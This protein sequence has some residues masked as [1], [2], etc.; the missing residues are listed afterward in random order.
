GGF[1]QSSS[2]PIVAPVYWAACAT[3]ND[4]RLPYSGA[5]AAAR[6]IV[7]HRLDQRQIFAVNPRGFTFHLFAVLP[8]FPRNFF[9][10]FDAGRSYYR[11]FRK[12][13]S[14]DVSWLGSQIPDVYLYG[15]K[16]LEPDAPLPIL[17][18][19]EVAK[20]CPGEMFWKDGVHEDES[21]VIFVRSDR[22]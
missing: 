3:I 9:D 18:G 17:R 1:L 5:P 22:R 14:A 11:F 20:V 16:G 4:L 19:Y 13:E 15:R 8:Y 21:I 12:P 2:D 6:Y 7:E 10:N